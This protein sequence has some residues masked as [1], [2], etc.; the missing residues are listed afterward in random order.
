MKAAR[1]ASGTKPAARKTSTSALKRTKQN[2]DI[3]HINTGDTYQN[4]LDK[5]TH[6]IG[7]TSLRIELWNFS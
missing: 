2:E 6:N 3:N 1:P 5:M 7:K 4:D